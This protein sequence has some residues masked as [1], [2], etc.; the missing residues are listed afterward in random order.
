M[1]AACASAALLLLVGL[2]QSAPS[3]LTIPYF[4]SGRKFDEYPYLSF[5]E[6]EK[7]LSNLAAQLRSETSEGS[8]GYVCVFSRSDRPANEARTRACRAKHYLVDAGGID[9]KRIIAMAIT[10]DSVKSKV[11]L[12]VW[13]REAPDDLVHNGSTVVYI[14]DEEAKTCNVRAPHKRSAASNKALQLTAR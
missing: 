13:L 7:H 5:K 1:T 14:S 6:E 2:A 11:E 3:D 12:W 8:K 9:S 10:D 4:D